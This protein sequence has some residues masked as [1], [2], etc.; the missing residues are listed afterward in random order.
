MWHAGLGGT[1]G[2][3]RGAL[4]ARSSGDGT[5]DGAHDDGCEG[6]SDDGNDGAVVAAA[7]VTSPVAAVGDAGVGTWTY[8]S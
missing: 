3:V 2:D 6:G 7:E 1:G 4:P 8:G 5:S